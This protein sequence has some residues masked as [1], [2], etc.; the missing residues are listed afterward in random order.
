[1]GRGAAGIWSTGAGGDGLHEAAVIGQD[2]LRGSRSTQ[3]PLV[4]P[5]P[6]RAVLLCK[7]ELVRD[8]DDELRAG[9]QLV[10]ARRRTSRE[11]EVAGVERFIEDENVR[12]HHRADAEAEPRLHAGRVDLQRLIE[13]RAEPRELGDLGQERADVASG[14]SEHQAVEIDVLPSGQIAVEPGSERQQSR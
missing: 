12:L 1:M 7:G 10:Q 4:Q 2:F 5:E 8:D 14:E 9:H 11:F 6:L 3:R 13:V